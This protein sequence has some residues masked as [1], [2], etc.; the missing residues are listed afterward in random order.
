M[1]KSLK[2]DFLCVFFK[3]PCFLFTIKEGI[4]DLKSVFYDVD[5]KICAC[6][7]YVYP[8][9]WYL[10]VVTWLKR[11]GGDP[12]HEYVLISFIYKNQ[13]CKAHDHLLCNIYIPFVL[14]LYMLIFFTAILFSFANKHKFII[15]CRSFV[16][17]C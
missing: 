5:D 4:N 15:V 12:P 1:L 11:G 9:P 13:A 6:Y 14:I 16:N 10:I 3:L 17:K 2:T 8:S 7:L